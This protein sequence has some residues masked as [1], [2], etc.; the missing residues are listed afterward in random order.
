MCQYSA[1]E[2]CPSDWHYRHLLNLS[3]SGAGLLMI[4]STAVEKKGRIT[5]NDLCIEIIK[6]RDEFKKLV[7]HLK[8]INDTPIGIQLSHSGRKGSSMIPWEKANSPLK[9]KKRLLDNRFIFRFK[10]RCPLA[11]AKKI[12]NIRDKQD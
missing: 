10:K 11:K 8:K 3:L 9:K 1:K 12:N 7:S 5:K 6:Q 2:G 4:E